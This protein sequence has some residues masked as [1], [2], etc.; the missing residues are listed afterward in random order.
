MTTTTTR[1]II[2]LL[3][4][5]L[6]SCERNS[7]GDRFAGWDY[8]YMK[9]VKKEL[10]NTGSDLIPAY[11]QLVAEADKALEKGPYSV[12]YKKMTPPGGT[13]NDYMSQGPYWWPDT[14]KPDGLPFI[15]RDG[16][17]YPEAG[18]DRNQLG[19]MMESVKTLTLAWFFTGEMKYA[20]R[21]AYITRVWFLDPETL[22]NPHLEYAQSIPGRTTGRGIGIIDVR[23]MH[24]LVD[25][26]VLLE[27]SGALDEAEIKGITEWFTAFFEWLTTSKNGKDEDD[28]HNNHSVAYDVIVSSIARYLGNNEYAASKISELPARRIDPMIEADGRQPEELIRTNAFGYS[29]G[30]LR[31]FFDAGETGLKVGVDI[32]G[33]S[34]PKGGSLRK[35]LDFLT[36]YIDREEDWQWQQIG[37]F[38]GSMN[39]LGLLIRR[40][41]RYYNEPEYKKL[42]E[43]KFEQKMKSDWTLLVTPGLQ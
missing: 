25:A 26:L 16:E 20:D 42:W 40:A 19:N 13:K 6:C 41:A 34:N 35:A 38:S 3:F 18:I 8:N 15:R 28:Y 22:M 4:L 23:G 29:S 9:S 1:L 43:D 14:T 27:G 32:F 10:K 31:N 2:T 17:R 12:T 33:Y 5:P 21:A 11:E 30:N 36:V 39:N 37:G 24:T 7:P